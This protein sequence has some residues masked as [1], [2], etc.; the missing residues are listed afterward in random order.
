MLH[1][2]TYFVKFLFLSTYTSIYWIFSR[3]VSKDTVL[4]ST[5][6]K[7]PLLRSIA[8]LF[9]LSNC[10]QQSSC[11]YKLT[12]TSHNVTLIE[13][14]SGSFQI[15]KFFIFWVVQIYSSFLTCMLNCIKYPAGI[16]LLKFNNGNTSRIREICSKLKN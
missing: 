7:M 10:R 16:Y 14:D 3:V 12:C 13:S 4:P 6:R 11:Y 15:E 1:S 9:N 2:H 5:L 8:Y